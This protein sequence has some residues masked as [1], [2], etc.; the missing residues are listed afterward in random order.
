MGQNRPTGQGQHISRKLTIIAQDPGFRKKRS[1]EGTIFTTKAELPAEE[2]LPGPTGYRV[3]VV[4]YDV[5]TDTLYVPA[6]LAP[7]SDCYDLPSDEQLLGDPRFHAQNVYAIV[8]RTLAR[9]EKALGRRVKWGCDGHQLHVIPHA[10]AEPNAFYSRADRSLFFGYFRGR[11]GKIIYTCL[12][13]DVIAHETTHAILDGLRSRFFEPSSPDQGAFHEGFADIV[14]MLSVFS[15]RDV[16][17]AMLDDAVASDEEAGGQAVPDPSSGAL[18]AKEKLRPEWLKKGAVF[19]LAD[20]MGRDL[21]LVRGSALRRSIELD[22]KDVNG[23]EFLEE[24]RRGE[25]LVAAMLN[26]FLEIWLNRIDEFGEILPGKVDRSLVANAGAHVADH[27]LTMAIRAIDYCPPVDLSF[28]DY[29]SALLTVD[30]EV[31]PDDDRYGYRRALLEQFERYGIR[32]SFGA[33]KDGTWCRC[34]AN[35]TYGRT[36]FDS[37]LRDEQE[38]FRFLW[39]NRSALEIDERGYIEIES[40]RP[41]VRVA[42]DGF[43]LRETIA[44]YVQ[45]LTLSAK[46][47][48]AMGIDVPERIR[49]EA[50]LRIYGGGALIFDEYGQLKYQ[51]AN[52]LD[53]GSW[54]RER[55]SVRIRHLAERGL[56]DSPD[57]ASGRLAAMHLARAGVE[58]GGHA[59]R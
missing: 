19:G 56:L 45:M 47:F 37:L 34:T 10:F 39:E 33:A 8:M 1:G 27:L 58:G 50:R 30:K 59:S 5:S 16:I 26:A 48:R 29:L 32:P 55:Q 13:H 21:S 7:N 20:E 41:A 6:E 35:L 42:P 24:H 36:H 23:P 14:A 49:G 38:V 40:V 46:E 9:F 22:P 11:D 43:I 25:I 57:D 2:L 4:D 17:E 3:K 12:S 51:I 44:E 53:N 15:L 28:S 31:V 18:I 54:D 52:H